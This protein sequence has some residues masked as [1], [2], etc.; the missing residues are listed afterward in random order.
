MSEKWRER[1]LAAILAAVMALLGIQTATTVSGCGKAPPAPECPEPK[2]DPKPDPKPEPEPEPEPQPPGEPQKAIGRVIM[3]GGYCSG[4]ILGPPRPDKRHMI[5]SAAHCFKGVNERINFQTLHDIAQVRSFHCTVVAI[6]RK[7]DVAILVS[8]DPQQGLPW[9][10][11]ADSTPSVN[12]EIWHAGFGRHNPG[13]LERGRVLAA[14]NRDNQVQYWLSVSPGDSGGGIMFNERG[15]VLSPVC[16][17]TRLD[18]PGNVWGGS[19]EV[20]NRMLT[21][22]ANF[23]EDLVPIEMPPPPKD[24]AIKQ[25]P[26]GMEDPKK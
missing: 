19:P 13:N 20:I 25:D 18:G 14:P 11:V 1:I 8:D 5:L 22:P 15:E 10:R 26:P 7:S 21:S 16:C 17:T 2:P 6:D 24:Q 4:T 12:T 23:S 9:V 3:A